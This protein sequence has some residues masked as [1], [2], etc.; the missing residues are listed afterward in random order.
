L[1]KTSIPEKEGTSSSYS[2]LLVSHGFVSV[3]VYIKGIK[4]IKGDGGYLS[5]REMFGAEF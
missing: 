1:S 4:G 2:Y 5:K 3:F